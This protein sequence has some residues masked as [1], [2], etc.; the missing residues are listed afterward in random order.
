MNDKEV[1]PAELYEV[2]VITHATRF[3][4]T[5]RRRVGEWI[6]H[7]QMNLL[8]A[9]TLTRIWV[10]RGKRP[11]IYALQSRGLGASDK[12]VLVTRRNLT[13]AKLL[14]DHDLSEILSVGYKT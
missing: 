1:H 6:T 2:D 7:Y 9:L 10:D 14:L 11:L 4:I 13:L 12:Q 8:D 3:A 5:Y